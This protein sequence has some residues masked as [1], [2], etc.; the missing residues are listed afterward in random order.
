MID[1]RID[2]LIEAGT[3]Y[4]E[5]YFDW[6]GKNMAIN[7]REFDTHNKMRTMT[8]ESYLTRFKRRWNN[9]F[10]P[11]VYIVVDRLKASDTRVEVTLMKIKRSLGDGF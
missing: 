3:E 10:Q 6:K 8:Y 11:Y 7:T 5:T 1:H 2:E 4:E 9:E